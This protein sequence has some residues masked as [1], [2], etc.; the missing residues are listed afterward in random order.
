VVEK[1]LELYSREKKEKESFNAC[2]ARL[3]KERLK[4]VLA[5]LMEVPSFDQNPEFYKDWGHENEKFAVRSGIKGECAGATVQE[6]APVMAQAREHLAQAEAFLAHGEFSPAQI[7]AY[8]AMA[9]AARVPLY[10]VLVDPFTSEQALWEFENIFV[11]SG[12]L[13]GEWLHLADKVEAEKKAG[14][15][16]ERTQGLI[17]LAK[18]HLAECERLHA[19]ILQAGAAGASPS[20]AQG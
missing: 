2:M 18:K 20:Q 3:G 13:A 1:L 4:E 19:E 7:E 16:E 5:P 9:S 17:A 12:R 10:A 8:E 6:K 11:R 15:T 14:P